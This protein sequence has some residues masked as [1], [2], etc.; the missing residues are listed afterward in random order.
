MILAYGEVANFFN[1]KPR[2]SGDD[3]YGQLEMWVENV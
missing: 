2:A 1:C 3:P